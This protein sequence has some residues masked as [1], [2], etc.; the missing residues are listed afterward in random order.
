VLWS[1]NKDN[2]KAGTTLIGISIDGSAALGTDFDPKK[3]DSDELSIIEEYSGTL[4][5]Y[6]GPEKFSDIVE[7]MKRKLDSSTNL[8]EAADNTA[9]EWSIDDERLS[10]GVYLAVLDGR[11]SFVIEPGVASLQ[12]AGLVAVGP[13]QE[14]ALAAIRAILVQPEVTESAYDIAKKAFEVASGVCVLVNFGA[15]ITI[16]GN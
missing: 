4:I 9:S 12:N 14:Y 6:T 10:K 8:G 5:G 2:K 16:L 1:K 15:N 11:E 13:G 7:T 3:R